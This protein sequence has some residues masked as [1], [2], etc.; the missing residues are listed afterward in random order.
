M[1]IVEKVKPLQSHSKG[2]EES[3]E[4]DTQEEDTIAQWLTKSANPAVGTDR[5]G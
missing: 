2:G 3:D 1:G 4:E 5:G